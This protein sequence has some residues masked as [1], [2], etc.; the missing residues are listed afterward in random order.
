MSD[1]SIMA[2]VAV[3]LGDPARARIMQALMD[4]KALTAKELAYVGRVAPQTASGHL[5]R[6]TGS[7]LLSVVRQGRFSY[8]RLASPLVARMVE[9]IMAV[10][11]I[12]A[13]PRH[14]PRS[15]G[16]DAL[17][18]ARTCYDHLAGR[19]GVAIADELAR[20]RLVVLG[21]DAGEVSAAGV[22]FLRDRMGL[23]IEGLRHRRR[24]FLRPCLDWS[25]RRPHMA[26]VIGRAIAERC[27]ALGWVER[28][29]DGRAVDITAVGCDAFRGMLGIDVERLRATR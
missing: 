9:S 23:E 4:G 7:N 14:R 25:E 24:V 5:A 27:F 26:G 3:L 29:R 22:A 11:A 13:P 8:Y 28:Q 21:E 18:L 12:E 10:A 20:R 17:R 19:L 15:S 6:L 2:E 1:G 16:D